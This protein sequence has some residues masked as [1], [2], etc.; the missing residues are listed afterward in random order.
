MRQS[1]LGAFGTVRRDKKNMRRC[2]SICGKQIEFKLV[3][4]KRDSLDASYASKSTIRPHSPLN[5]AR[6]KD[7]TTEVASERELIQDVTA[8]ILRFLASSTR[9]YFTY[10]Q[11]RR[12]TSAIRGEG[13]QHLVSEPNLTYGDRSNT[14][15]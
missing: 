1:P 10:Y 9:I 3:G 15:G 11:R 12:L 14:T 6:R 4:E 13:P 8:S 2:R 5:L 7:R